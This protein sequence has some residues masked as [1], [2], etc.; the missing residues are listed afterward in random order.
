MWERGGG[1]GR[2][3]VGGGVHGGWSERWSGSGGMGT[4]G[5]GGGVGVGSKWEV[6]WGM[7]C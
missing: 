1:V 4:G 5:G 6:E 7:K 2:K 3:E